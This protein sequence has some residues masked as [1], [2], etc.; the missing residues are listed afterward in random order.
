M[1]ATVLWRPRGQP[2]WSLSLKSDPGSLILVVRETNVQ[3]YP[4]EGQRQNQWDNLQ[5]S[6]K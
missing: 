2:S 4:R 1:E 5:M 3:I 6:S